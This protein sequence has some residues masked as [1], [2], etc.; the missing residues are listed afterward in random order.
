M[1]EAVDIIRNI[2]K[3]KFDFYF[4][5]EVKSDK[6]I[7]TITKLIANE[8]KLKQ[9]QVVLKEAKFNFG[10][11]DSDPLSEMKFFDKDNE[12]KKKVSNYKSILVPSQFEE[13]ITRIYCTNRDKVHDV[14]DA[15]KKILPQISKEMKTPLCTVS[16]SKSTCASNLKSG[17]RR[18]NQKA[19]GK[20]GKRSRSL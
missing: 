8:S 14:K 9:G 20:H 7:N 2:Q 13:K 4:C 6:G 11:K 16:K 10:K 5:D 15:V 12:L 18:Q 1:E 17:K 19:L 3:R